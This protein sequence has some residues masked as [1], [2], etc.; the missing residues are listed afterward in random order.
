M[1]WKEAY[2]RRGGGAGEGYTCP[3]CQQRFQGPEGFQ[4]LHGDH[5]L[6]RSMGGRTTWENLRLLCSSCK[7]SKGNWT[8]SNGTRS[9]A[10]PSVSLPRK[11]VQ[12]SENALLA[13]EDTSDNRIRILFLAAEPT[14]RRRVA[15]DQE[16]RAIKQ[17]IQAAK[18]SERIEFQSEWAVTADGLENALLE[19]QPHVLHISGHGS[20]A[21]IY[22]L[23]DSRSESELLDHSE[24]ATLLTILR[25]D[26]RL[27]VLN[28]C[29]SAAYVEAIVQSVPFAVGMSDELPVRAAVAFS[30]VFYRAIGFGRDVETAFDLGKFALQRLKFSEAMLP[31]LRKRNQ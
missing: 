30:A 22:L 1:D 18:Y 31:H 4:G 29:H 15:L 6:P 5:I 19:F 24:L 21:G 13:A 20:P 27:V 2:F 7:A 14:D 8:S 26:L 3:G 28:T 16:C 23:N 11:A 25:D 9:E 10:S 17:E 12:P